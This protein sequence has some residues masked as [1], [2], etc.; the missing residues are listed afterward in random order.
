VQTA[1]PSLHRNATLAQ[2][3]HFLRFTYVTLPG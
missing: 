3:L 1:H 2:K